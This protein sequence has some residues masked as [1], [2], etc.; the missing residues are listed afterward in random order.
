MNCPVCKHAEHHVLRSTSKEGAIRR[1][2]QCDQCG[3][4]WATLE[5]AEDQIETD[6]KA[7][8]KARELA[9]ALVEG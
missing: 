8:A 7:L 5:Q 9:A 6:R 2:R 1:V 4:R 3:H